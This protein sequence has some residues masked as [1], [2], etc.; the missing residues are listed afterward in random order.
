[1]DL[2]ISV[3][4][5]TTFLLFYIFVGYPLIIYVLARFKPRLPEFNRDYFPSVDVIIIVRNA[6]SYVDKK[7]NS[8]LNL[9]YP[10]EKIRIRVVTDQS[11]DRTAAIFKSYPQVDLIENTVK[12]S[13]PACLN[14]VIRE[15][16]AE[17]LLLTDIRQPLEKSCLKRLACHFSDSS[18]GAVSGELVLMESDDNFASGMDAYW[19]YEKF[20]RHYESKFNSVPGVTGAIYA[21]RREYYEPIPPETL[22]DDVLIPM[23]LV[24]K[25]KKIL[26]ESDAVAFDI[27]SS[28]I[29]RERTRKTRT[30]AGNWQLMQLRPQLLNPLK[31]AIWF[32]FVSH[33]I[34]RLLS[35]FLLA[36][37][38]LASL[39]A[40]Q[41]SMLFTLVF[42]LQVFVYCLLLLCIKVPALLKIRIIKLAYSFMALMYFS[43]LGFIFFITKK[44]LE[45]WK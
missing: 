28:D 14:Q 2:S 16:Q 43:L 21:M 19:R 22:L 37:M 30:L 44:H 34:L 45:L 8:I 9:D 41:N 12:S 26:F 33:K 24:L 7:I 6:E 1:M 3:F 4:W 38:L 35:P 39:I 23:N 32:Q 40:S 25:G 36:I 10:A 5:I 11:E 29:K 42:V 17:V 18:I 20:I 27:P 15:S 13:K 31:N